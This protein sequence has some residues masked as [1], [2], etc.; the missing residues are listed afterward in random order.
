MSAE[1]LEKAAT[2]NGSVRQ[3]V[4]IV[5]LL[6]TLILSGSVKFIADKAISA[7]ERVTKLEGEVSGDLKEMRAELRELRRA[8]ERMEKNGR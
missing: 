1:G 5:A 3:T 4:A 8:I 6:T 2:G 7:D